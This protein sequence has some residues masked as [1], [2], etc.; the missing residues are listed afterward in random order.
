MNR[1]EKI[2]SMFTVSAEILINNMKLMNCMIANR[3][4]DKQMRTKEK[5][6]N[7]A[8]FKYYAITDMQDFRRR[9]HRD[10]LQYSPKA[11]VSVNLFYHNTSR[12]NP[13]NNSSTRLL[14]KY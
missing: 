11:L 4:K 13:F 2:K 6:L 12:K 7:Y 5:G 8:F 14:Y 1:E 10:R 3:R 9:A